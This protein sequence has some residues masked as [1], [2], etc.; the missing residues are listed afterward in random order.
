MKNQN[1]LIISVV[2]IVLALITVAIFFGTK[3]Q[4][5]PAKAVVSV[6]LPD[7]KVDG[8]T[9]QFANGLG[10]AGR[11]GSSIGG[12]RG[13][14]IPNFGQMGGGGAPS[15]PMGMAS[16]GG[17][18]GGAPARPMGMASPGGGGAPVTPNGK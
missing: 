18:G 11:N 8:A 6:A 16:P 5:E 3:P 13:P 2:A 9:V 4:P 15:R 17:G 1:D 12:G 14:G 10:S 7:A